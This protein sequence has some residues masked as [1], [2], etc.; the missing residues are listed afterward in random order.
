VRSPFTFTNNLSILK[1]FGLSASHEAMK[2]EMRL[3]AENAF[4]HPVFG[5]PDTGVGDPTFGVISYMGIA[6][7]QCQ[8]ALKFYF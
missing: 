3:E 7:R 5:T 1:E 4:N 6:A 8:L 2:L